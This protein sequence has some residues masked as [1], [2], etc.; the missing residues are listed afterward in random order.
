MMTIEDFRKFVQDSLDAQDE[1]RKCV[2]KLPSLH[3]YLK[4]DLS[5]ILPDRSYMFETND[6]GM[7]SLL[8]QTILDLK[9][10]MQQRSKKRSKK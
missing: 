5:Y 7:M 1:E 6:F 8:G 3:D 10:E 4:Q 9:D 2:S